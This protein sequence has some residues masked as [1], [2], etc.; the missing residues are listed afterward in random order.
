MF[1]ILKN[2]KGR[3]LISYLLILLPVFLQAQQITFSEPFREDSRDMN[4]DII[5]R[6]KGNIVVF[7]N[8]RWKYSLNVYNDSMKLKEKVELDFI[9]NKTFN[10]DYIAYPDFFYLIY[11]HQKKGV[12]YCMA[13]KIDANGKKMDE[14]VIL[15]TTQIGMLGE[16]KIYTTINSE[17]KKKIM[18]FKIQHKEDKAHFAMVLFD[19]Q[20]N[21][22]HK[23]RLQMDYDDRKDAF[24]DF[25]MDNDGNLVFAT[26]SKNNN[27]ENPSAISLVT[28]P[29]DQDS[30]VMRKLDLNN[31]FIDEVK[32][33]VDNVNK[34]YLLNSFYYKERN[35]NIEGVFI[36][37]QDAKAN[38]VY[39]NVFTEFNSELR[40]LVRSSGSVRTAFNDFYIRN[41]VLKRDGSFIMVAEDYTSQSSGLNNFNRYDY[42]Y[43]SPFGSPYNYSYYNPGYYGY[44]RP[45]NSFRNEGIRYYYDNVLVLSVAKDGIT[46]WTNIIHKQQYSDD[47]DN[48][49]S[50]NIFNSGGELHFLYNDISKRDKLLS[51][52]IIT[53]DGSSRRSPTLRTYERGYEFM[54]RFAKQTGARQVIIPCTIRG[55]ICFAKVDF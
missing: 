28:K 54:P 24:S 26:T 21:I 49:L 40:S 30:F 13:V 4:F 36:H 18:I 46:D 10:V 33:K 31:T 1:Q 8:M 34:R 48:F 32:I 41:I 7:K 51:D 27:R 50:Y 44:Y 37:L 55:L 53:A 29:E 47:N 6:M 15:D 22:L 11:Q 14:P 17:D 20:L 5:G 16:N 42:L 23:T 3:Y 25:L 52:N 2:M 12:L 38:E 19:S 43:G 9:P 35:G 39:R 45:F